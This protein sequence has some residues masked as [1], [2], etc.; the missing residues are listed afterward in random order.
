M[1]KILVAYHSQSGNTE[2]L[3]RS[4]A[5]GVMSTENAHA[6]FKRAADTTARDIKDCDALVICSPEYFGYMA[7]AIKDLFDR[8]YEELKEDPA[9]KKKPFCIVISAGNDGSGALAH[10]ER[11]CKGY[12]FKRVQHPV[13][14]KGQVTEEMLAQ[15]LELGKTV[16]EGVNAG[17]F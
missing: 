2:R 9:T 3:A 5:Q 16:A 12:R 8:T 4:V 1:A 6:V 11:I 7:G 10:I 14:C 15:C 17:I 13:V